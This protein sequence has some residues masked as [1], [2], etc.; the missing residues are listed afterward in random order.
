VGISLIDRALHEHPRAVVPLWR[1]TA[2][3]FA[4]ILVAAVAA[5]GELTVAES[6]RLNGLLA[7]F[8]TSSPPWGVGLTCT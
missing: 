4:A 2:Q 6:A 8:L 5:D 3:A 7:S 1:P